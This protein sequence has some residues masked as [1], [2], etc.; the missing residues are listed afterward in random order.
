MA[1]YP[2]LEMV[3]WIDTTNIAAWTALDEISEWAADGGFV[4][5]NVGY[6]VH[7]DDECVVLAAR[8]ALNASPEQVGL[9]E[10]I[11]KGVIRHRWTLR[12][13]KETP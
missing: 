2:P 11:P 4:C 8:V 5:R 10:R 6:L 3:E 12:T 13:A 1:D 9:Y 7:E